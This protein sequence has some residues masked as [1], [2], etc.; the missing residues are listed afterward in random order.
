[1][2]SVAAEFH[3][4]AASPQGAE[5]AR[6]CAPAPAAARDWS[7]FGHGDSRAAARPLESSR[8]S[9]FSGASRNG[10]P[11]SPPAPGSTAGG[12]SCQ[13]CSWGLRSGDGSSGRND[14]DR[15]RGGSHQGSYEQTHCQDVAGGRGSSETI[16]GDI[17]YPVAAMVTNTQVQAEVLHR[18]CA[19]PPIAGRAAPI[20]LCVRPLT[21]S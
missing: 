3:G 8:G 6:Y 11:S 16:S 15:S 10:V 7:A 4:E 20:R 12:R 17:C 1:M 21:T 18:P 2:P 5:L 9:P 14:R 13:C 19:S